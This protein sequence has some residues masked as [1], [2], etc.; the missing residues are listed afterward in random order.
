MRS[1]LIAILFVCLLQL[2]LFAQK[3]FEAGV[4]LTPQSPWIL[5]NT[6]FKKGAEL[7]YKFNGSL[8]YGA[9][10]SMGFTH[11]IGVRI[12]AIVS[13]MGQKYTTA[14]NF[15]IPNFESSVKLDYIL[16]PVLFR[17]T[18]SLARTKTAFQLMAGPQYG[19]LRRARFE[20]S[21]FNTDVANKFES[22]DLSAVIGLGLTREVLNN[23]FFQASFRMAYSL[24][25]IE[26]AQ[27]NRDESRN[28]SVGIQLG[29]AYVFTKQ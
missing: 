6:D 21:S 1:N 28:A 19:M 8:A 15:V 25:N 9:Q 12:E 20:S 18:G 23:L 10:M 7:D 13:R 29:V 22:A 3:G 5:N 17:Y 2:P 24:K 11:K 26:L 4:F 14:S 16:I 27:P